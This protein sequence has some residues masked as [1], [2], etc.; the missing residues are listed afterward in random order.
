MPFAEKVA[1]IKMHK[2]RMIDRTEANICVI[3]GEPREETSHRRKTDKPTEMFFSS[4]FAEC[5]CKLPT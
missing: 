2:R 4:I 1:F 3:H 5:K